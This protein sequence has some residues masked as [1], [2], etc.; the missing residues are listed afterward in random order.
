MTLDCAAVVLLLVFGSSVS[1]TS[2]VQS[3]GHR[4]ESGFF[5]DSFATLIK[6]V[7]S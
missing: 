2:A 1:R 3:H 6:L 5:Q 7:L 4:F